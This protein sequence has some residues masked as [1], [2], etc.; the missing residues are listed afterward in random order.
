MNLLSIYQVSLEYKCTAN[1]SVR[2]GSRTEARQLA[3][4]DAEIIYARP[5][6]YTLDNVDLELIDPVVVKIKKWDE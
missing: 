6:C 4:K 5:H 3:L 2:A 1:I